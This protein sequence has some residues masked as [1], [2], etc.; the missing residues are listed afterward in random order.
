MSLLTLHL[1]D[2]RDR[3]LVEEQVVERPA[4]PSPFLARQAGL[5]AYQHP[6]ARCRR[7][8][9]ITREQAGVV[10]EQRL[11][12]V[13]R[14]VPLLAHL[15]QLAASLEHE[16]RPA[17]VAPPSGLCALFGSLYGTVVR[18]PMRAELRP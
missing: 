6:A 4:V 11:Q 15:E 13:F 8:H 10:R 9:L 1:D 5:P 7:V 2:G 14:E 12:V 17:H 3:L 16:D 18:H